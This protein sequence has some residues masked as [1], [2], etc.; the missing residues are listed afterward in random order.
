LINPG[1][2]SPKFQK[3]AP[4]EFE[5]LKTSPIEFRLHLGLDHNEAEQDAIAQLQQIK[6]YSSCWATNSARM[7][8]LLALCSVAAG[9]ERNNG[10][11]WDFPE[12]RISRQIDLSGCLFMLVM[13]GFDYYTDGGHAG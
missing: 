9:N 1:N 10:F 2:L 13:S 6:E 4:I 7:R 12:S 8:S 3:I 5:F 11:S